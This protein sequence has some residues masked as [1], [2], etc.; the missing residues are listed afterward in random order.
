MDQD[1]MKK[2]IADGV[3]EGLRGVTLRIDVG[4]RV[5]MK[6]VK[7]PEKNTTTTEPK[8]PAEKPKSHKYG[9]GRR[10]TTTEVM[11]VLSRQPKSAKDVCRVL[12]VPA[13]VRNLS[14]VNGLLYTAFKN[15]L[16]DKVQN[17]GLFMQKNGG[18]AK[19]S[20]VVA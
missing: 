15:G 3:R 16:T 9:S 7:L 1:E 10:F 18:S 5:V 14:R 12:G 6:P 17:T 8:K 20:S 4:E 19:A 13:T 2:L 11:G